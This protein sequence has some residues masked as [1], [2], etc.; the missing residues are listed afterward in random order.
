[1]TAQRELWIKEIMADYPKISRYF[2]ELMVDVYIKD[3]GESMRKM[4]EQLEKAEKKGSKKQKQAPLEVRADRATDVPGSVTVREP[5]EEETKLNFIP[6]IVNDAEQ[7]VANNL[8][9]QCQS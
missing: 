6:V 1:M 3:G 4:K 8:L 9:E 2:A 7:E 5:N